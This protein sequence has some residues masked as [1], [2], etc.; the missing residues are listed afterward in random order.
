MLSSSPLNAADLSRAW[1][2]V[3]TQQIVLKSINSKRKKISN[4]TKPGI[5]PT[6]S[7]RVKQ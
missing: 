2:T 1:H 7:Y 4:V 6:G 5:R 3:G